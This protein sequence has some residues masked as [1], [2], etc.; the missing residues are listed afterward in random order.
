MRKR[1]YTINNGVFISCCLE[2]VFNVWLPGV[3]EE[4][5][6]FT[7]RFDTMY[8]YLSS[9][10]S[11]KLMLVCFTIMLASFFTRKLKKKFQKGF[12]GI[13]RKTFSFYKKIVKEF[14]EFND[15]ENN[16]KG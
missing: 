15:E 4:I 1:L 11:L 16:F 6:S 5:L 7:S 14:K 12:S 3:K 13:K 9:S 2:F 10:W 8:V